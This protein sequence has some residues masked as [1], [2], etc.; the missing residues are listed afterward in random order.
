MQYFGCHMV[1]FVTCPMP[2]DT[3]TQVA[4]HVSITRAFQY[5][6]TGVM[7]LSSDC[8]GQWDIVS[9]FGPY[10]KKQQ[11][12]YGNTQIYPD[13]MYLSHKYLQVHWY[14]QVLFDSA[15][16]LF[17][18]FGSCNDTT[19]ANRYSVTLHRMY[20]K[21]KNKCLTTEV[22]KLLDSSGFLWIS[23]RFVFQNII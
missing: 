5:W 1:Y 14:C 19:N 18:D 20:I 8:F 23:K 2:T 3:V 11:A 22:W 4:S 13:H 21:I 15:R 6:H 10:D 12:Y 17:L 9:P 7:C 16:F